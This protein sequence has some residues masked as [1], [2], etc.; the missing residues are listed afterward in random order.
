M[1]GVSGPI[2]LPA[3]PLSGPLLWT[4]SLLGNA[5]I[6]LCSKGKKAQWQSSWVMN[7]CPSNKS[8]PSTKCECLFVMNCPTYGL[9]EPIKHRCPLWTYAEPKGKH[10]VTITQPLKP[11]RRGGPWAII[12]KRNV[13]FKETSLL[14]NL[15]ASMV[16]IQ[17]PPFMLLGWKNNTILS[18]NQDL[19]RHTTVSCPHFLKSAIYLISWS[20]LHLIHH[21]LSCQLVPSSTH[22]EVVTLPVFK[23]VLLIFHYHCSWTLPF[24]FGAT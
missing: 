16:C 12:N 3:R 18:C 21:C 14:I 7:L 15:W 1:K 4:T 9:A 19:H 22:K 2:Y 13:A 17:I 23:N 5:K 24:V 8:I 6:L 20:S 11:I 10:S